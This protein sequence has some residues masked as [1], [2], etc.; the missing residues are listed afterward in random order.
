MMVGDYFS[1]CQSNLKARNGEKKNERCLP[2]A[3]IH[4]LNLNKEG[5]T[6]GYA[7]RELCMS[8]YV[9]LRVFCRSEGA[10]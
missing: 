6:A 4:H 10:K 2:H 5:K 1:V 3:L 9:L 7:I 8:A